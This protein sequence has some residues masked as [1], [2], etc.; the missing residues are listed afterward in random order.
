MPVRTQRGR[1]AVYRRAWGWPLRSPRHL[2]GAATGLSVLAI[3]LGMVV[4][5]LSPADPSRA[6]RTGA[7][8]SGYQLPATT[9]HAPITNPR[10]SVPPSSAP[11]PNAPPPSQGAVPG[12]T[13][14]IADAFARGWVTHPPGIT[15]VQ[16]A[17]QIR[18]WTTEAYWPRLLTVDPASVPSSAVTGPPKPVS[19]TR[20]SIEIDVPTDAVVL[21]LTLVL[22]PVGWRVAS[23]G[24]AE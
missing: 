3:G 13:L 22:T 18:P 12:K 20:T 6:G 14:A 7:A 19:R 24:P 15:S 1:A 10:G 21:R 17:E 11:A 16:W 23:Y 4:P 8:A 5:A 2:A 9:T